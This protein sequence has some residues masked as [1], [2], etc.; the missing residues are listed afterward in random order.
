[1]AEIPD[2][3]LLEQYARENS[4]RA[5]A[6]IVVRHIALV[7]SVALRHVINPQH[8]EDITQAVFI[9]LARKAARL[10]RKTVLSGWLY[11]TAR[12]TAANFQRAEI[13][14][15]HREQEA[16]MQST[17][18]ETA[19]D[20]LWPELMSMLDDAMSRLGAHERDALVLRYFQNKSLAEVGAA[21]GLEERT[22]QKR[23]HRALEKL[24]TYFAKHGINSTTETIAG[25]ISANSI[26]VAPVALAK[27][28]T[29]MALAKGAT[30]TTSTLTL[31][32]GALKLMAWQK[33][34]M[35]V[36]VGAAT[37]L[38]AGTTAMAVDHKSQDHSSFR[39]RMADDVWQLISGVDT[40]RLVLGIS[41]SPGDKS[42]SPTNIYLTI[43][44][45]IKGP[46][47][48]PIS[49]NGLFTNF[50][51]DEA[52]RRENPLVTF[53]QQHGSITAW[54]S[55]PRPDG[56]VF[57]YRVFGD[58]VEE[59]NKTIANYNKLMGPADLGW[60]GYIEW[61]F[62]PN[63]KVQGVIVIFPKSG[64]RK[65]TVQILAASGIKTY[66]ANGRGM[67]RLKLDSALLRENPQVRLSQ[68]GGIAPDIS[69]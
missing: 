9:I 66:T 65:A 7:H 38:A 33:I 26:Q 62:S 24:R 61:L 40:N 17:L 57:D 11:H 39:Y 12:L 8:A 43:H 51:H 23:V 18:Q 13:R 34:K 6:A 36:M 37:I 50:P 25:A 41:L 10:G 28:V 1:M 60:P 31:V 52:L 69:M 55:I 67:V 3:D 29:A 47:Q 2:A 15:V 56:L 16:Y 48:V 35:A 63:L 59:L 49:T 20:P 14:R 42:A 5:F 46:I 22:A 19:P 27:S 45:A 68:P 44:S 58:G 32:K 54:L 30:A 21:M 4:G 53:S 64:A